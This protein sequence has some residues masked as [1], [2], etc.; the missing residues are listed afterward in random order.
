MKHKNPNMG[1]LTA[2]VREFG[3]SKRAQDF[4]ATMT[5]RKWKAWQFRYGV[6]I[7]GHGRGLNPPMTWW[8]KEFHQALRLGTCLP[9]KFVQ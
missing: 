2:F 6:I 4:F 7:E 8:E 9:N 1:Y 3:G 5:D